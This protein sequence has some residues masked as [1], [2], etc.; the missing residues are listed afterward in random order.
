MKYITSVVISF[1]ISSLVL[2]N[3][4]VA[5]TIPGNGLADLAAATGVNTKAVGFFSITQVIKPEGAITN[6]Q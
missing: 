2:G 4:V 3:E 6:L 1:V 5:E